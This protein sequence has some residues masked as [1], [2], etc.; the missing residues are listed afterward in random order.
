MCHY[1]IHDIITVR[2][3]EKYV[4]LDVIHDMNIHDD[5]DQVD[6]IFHDHV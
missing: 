2:I 6:V 1:I 4:H 3:R 5:T